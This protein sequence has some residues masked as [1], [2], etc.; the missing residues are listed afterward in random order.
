MTRAAGY[1]AAFVLVLAALVALALLAGIPGG[2]VAVQGAL[3]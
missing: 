3:W 1:V 2:M